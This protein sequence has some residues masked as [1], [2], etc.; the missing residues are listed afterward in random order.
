M[1][2]A[3]VP[4]D[5]DGIPKRSHVARVSTI[6]WSQVLRLDFRG[7]RKFDP[8]GRSTVFAGAGLAQSFGTESPQSHGRRGSMLQR[9]TAGA[10]EIAVGL[11]VTGQAGPG[12]GW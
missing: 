7:P 9:I 12:P 6:V 4:G 8:I 10:S 1:V 11:I 2:A 5:V 3:P